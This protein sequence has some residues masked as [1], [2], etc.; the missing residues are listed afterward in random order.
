MSIAI[1]PGSFDPFT[2]GHLHIAE[3][4]CRLFDRL[5][6]AVAEQNYKNTLFNLEERKSFIL[7]AISH[8]PNCDIAVYQDLTVKLARQCGASAIIRGLRAIS[9][10][11]Y[12]MQVAAVNKHLDEEIETVFLMANA[13]YTFISSSTIK[14]VCSAGGSISGLVTPMVENAMR[15]KLS[16]SVNRT[17]SN[18]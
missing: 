11:E 15:K 13:D 12:E 4:A 6:I 10:Y 2:V 1:Y 3:R 17:V 8:L 9:D 16:G 7:D 14:Q 18:F 5:I